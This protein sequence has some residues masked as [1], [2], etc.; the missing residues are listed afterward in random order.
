MLEQNWLRKGDL[1]DQRY[2]IKKLIKAGGMGAVY[3]AEDTARD[4]KVCAVK[5]MLDRFDNQTERR[6]AIDRFLSEIQVLGSLRHPNIPRVTDHFLDK[7]SFF[8]VMEY[9][10]GTDLSTKLKENKKGF[11]YQQVLE[12]MIEVLYALE[13]IHNIEPP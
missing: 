1:L 11:P 2:R 12:W 9:I 5:Q 4:D 6:E 8:F 13:Y 7:N 3:Q 10:H